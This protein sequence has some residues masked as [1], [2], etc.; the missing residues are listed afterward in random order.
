M[1]QISICLSDLPKE[2]IILSSK[3]QKKYITLN[4]AK[5]KEVSKYGETHTLYVPKS[6]EERETPTVY[7]GS[8]KEFEPKP[9][10]DNF[11]FL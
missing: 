7:V 4:L 3:N 6:K 2:K 8:G 10:E 1:I 11:P 5:R 9:Q